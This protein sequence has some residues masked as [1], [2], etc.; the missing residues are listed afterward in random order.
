VRVTFPPRARDVSVA[1]SP[2]GLG[3]AF[4]RVRQTAGVMDLFVLRLGRDLAPAGEPEQL[5]FDGRDISGIAWTP[6]SRE[7]VFSSDRG[8]RRELWRIA[9]DGPKEPKR[10]TG[11]G[12]DGAWVAISREG[13]ASRVFTNA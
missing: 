6:D 13:G 4:A 8:G 12:E 3:V 10:L 2:D 11:A 1:I 7:I 5:T 9:C